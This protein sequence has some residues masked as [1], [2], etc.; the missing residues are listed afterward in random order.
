MKRKK[1]K[2]SIFFLVLEVF[3]LSL[4]VNINFILKMERQGNRN[5]ILHTFA[6][7]SG[8]AYRQAEITSYLSGISVP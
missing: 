4:M 1:K 5:I 3:L 2:R 7:S 8:K 6:L